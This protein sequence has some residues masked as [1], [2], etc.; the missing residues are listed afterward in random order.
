[1]ALNFCVSLPLRVFTVKVAW[2]VSVP[3]A[4]ANLPVPLVTLTVPLRVTGAG[5][6]LVG[7]AEAVVDAL[8]R[9]DLTESEPPGPFKTAVPLTGSEA[10]DVE[11]EVV[12]PVAVT[13]PCPRVVPF[14]APLM[15]PETRWEP[16]RILTLPTYAAEKLSFFIFVAWALAV[17]AGTL[18]VPTAAAPETPIL[19]TLMA[20]AAARR[21]T[22]RTFFITSPFDNPPSLFRVWTR[23]RVTA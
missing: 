11:N 10:L 14:P 17:T 1:V 19:N 12:A 7:L 8:A 4:P 2:I 16:Q 20:A 15:V 18:C 9:T 13:E 3:V 21:L 6:V 5:A 22:L 23:I